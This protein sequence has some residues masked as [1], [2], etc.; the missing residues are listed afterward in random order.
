MDI[1]PLEYIER[2][3]FK[4]RKQIITKVNEIVEKVNESMDPDDYY[5]KSEIDEIVD[6]IDIPDM[7]N[8]YT[9]TQTDYKISA[10][11]DEL[12]YYENVANN[13][14]V[15]IINNNPA[16]IINNVQINDIISIRSDMIV[17]D[18]SETITDTVTHTSMI[19]TMVVNDMD[20][21]FGDSCN[22]Y[23]TNNGTYLK[24]GSYTVLYSSA[25]NRLTI[26]PICKFLSSNFDTISGKIT[27]IIIKSARILRGH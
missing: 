17:I 24:I 1:E 14:T 16:I 8:Y 22:I 12:K 9:K 11:G 4:E 7:D 23:L 27:N 5:T 15:T 25:N 20:K 3:A 10:F 21:T 19:V 6:N 2:T 13:I 26:I 18:E